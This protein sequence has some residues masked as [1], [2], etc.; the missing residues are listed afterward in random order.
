MIISGRSDAGK[1]RSINQDSLYAKKMKIGRHKVCVAAVSDGIGSFKEG[2]LASNIITRSIRGWTEENLVQSIKNNEPINTIMTQMN[3]LLVTINNY[4]IYTASMQ[5]ITTGATISFL[6]IVDNQYAVAH[7]GDSRIYKL[8]NMGL[9]IITRDHCVMKDGKILLAQCV[10]HSTDIDIF[11]TTGSV[12]KRDVFFVC[13]DGF[14]KWV[15]LNRLIR[16]Q[17]WIFNTYQLSRYTNNSFAQ[18]KGTYC[19]DD[20]SA[21]IIKIV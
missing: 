21:V 16:N 10:G 20:I 3:E 12:Q 6:V 7:I 9:S 8:G 5:K 4:I 17:K 2:G 15:D 11:N 14:Y 19:S 13:S 1:S 18:V